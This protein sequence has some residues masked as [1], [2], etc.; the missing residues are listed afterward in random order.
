MCD[1]DIDGDGVEN[2]LGLVIGENEQ[3]LFT[4]AVIDQEI[5]EEQIERIKN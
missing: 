3:C 1:I 4:P 5:I 2:M